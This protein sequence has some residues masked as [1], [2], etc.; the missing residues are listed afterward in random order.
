M[1]CQQTYEL[2][3]TGHFLFFIDESGFSQS[4]PRTH[5]YS[6]KGV[7]CYGIHDWGT[8]GRTNVIGALAG[9][10]LFATALFQPNINTTIFHTWMMESLIPKLSNKSVRVHGGVKNF[11][12]QFQSKLE[13]CILIP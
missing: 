1:F 4:M 8:K 9:K 11:I 6:S 7:R 10:D 5:G 2:K 3:S 12:K 13:I